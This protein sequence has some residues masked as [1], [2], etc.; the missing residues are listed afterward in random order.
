MSR[1]LCVLGLLVATTSVADPVTRRAKRSYQQQHDAATQELILHNEFSTV[2]ILRGTLLTPDFRGDLSDYREV[3]LNP[4]P[5]N[6]ATFEARMAG[7][8]DAYHEVVFSADSGAQSKMVFG[9][10]DD[11]WNIRLTADGTPQELVTV[12]RVR[13]PTP[14]HLGLYLQHNRW[15]KLYI[16][17]FHRTVESPSTVVMHVGSGH[18]NGELAWQASR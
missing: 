13:N 2:L 1:W 8:A 15:S 5:D 16:A 3:L 10:G 7:D 17:R 14:L 18:G 4:A 9:P 6:Q 11:R 12:Y